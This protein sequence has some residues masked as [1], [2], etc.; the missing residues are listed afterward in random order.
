MFSIFSKKFIR[1]LNNYFTRFEK[2]LWFFSCSVIFITSLF[3]GDDV[4]SLIAS[5]I[6]VTSLIFCAKGNP[7]GQF[8]MILF[9]LLYGYISYTFSYYGEMFTYLGMT[10]PMATFSLISWLKNPYKG[11]RNEVTISLLKAKDY[12]ILIFL[13]VFVTF[14]FYYILSYFNTSYLA[15]STVSIATSFFA[16]YLTLKRSHFYAMAYACND[17]ILIFLWTLAS[18][19]NSSYIPV[20]ICFTIFLIN[21]LYGFINW[22][23]I[24]KRQMAI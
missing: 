1:H 18:V 2:I 24:M 13:T 23:K 7:I 5:L 16:V 17:I 3:F 4:I 6:G 9:S 22:K 10:M 20:I 15:L 19:E 12:I 11:N 21:D 8:L 14:V